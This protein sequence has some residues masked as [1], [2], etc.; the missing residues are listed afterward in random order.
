LGILDRLRNV[1]KKEKKVEADWGVDQPKI[2]DAPVKVET[3]KPKKEKYKAN[4]DRA[5]PGSHGMKRII[6]MGLLLIYGFFSFT[7]FTKD[8]AVGGIFFI[9]FYILLDYVAITTKKEDKWGVQQ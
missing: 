7:M 8:Y 5:I 6:A 2:E 9:T 3:L 1:V 4:L